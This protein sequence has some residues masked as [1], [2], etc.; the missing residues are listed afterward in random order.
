VRLPDATSYAVA[1]LTRSD[2]SRRA[3][4]RMVDA[5]IGAAAAHAVDVLRG[6]PGAAP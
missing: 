5:A 3:D 4:A 6:E 2:P 1:V